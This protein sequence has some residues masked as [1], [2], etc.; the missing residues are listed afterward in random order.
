MTVSQ[1]V[2]YL[3]VALLALLVTQVSYATEIAPGRIINPG[4]LQLKMAVAYNS[5]NDEYFLT[6]AGT[7]DGLAQPAAL[8]ARLSP[9]GTLLG[10]EVV[11]SPASF[12]QDVSVAYNP[13]RNEYLVVWRNDGPADIF[14]RYLDGNGNP[15]GG[16]FGIAT[17]GDPEVD[18]EI[19]YST[20][21]KRYMVLWQ[22]NRSNIPTIVYRM[23]DGD[24]TS[25]TPLIGGEVTV[26]SGALSSEVAY[27]SVSN[28]FLVVFS[29]ETFFGQGVFGMF[30]AGDGSGVTSGLLTLDN[31]PNNQQTPRIAYAPSNDRWLVTFADW[32]QAGSNSA[33][34]N[35]VLVNSAGTVVKQFF[36]VAT[37]RAGNPVSGGWD[38]PGDVAFNETTGTFFATWRLEPSA[39]GREVNP[40]DGSLL[41]PV[42][43]SNEDA[44]PIA[45]TTRPDILDPQALVL[46]RSSVGE[47]GV[48]V[49]IVSLSGFPVPI[50]RI[51]DNSLPDAFFGVFYSH[52]LNVIGDDTPLTFSV[53]SGN[54][55]SIGLSLGATNGTISGT[56][57]QLGSFP[58]TFR[59]E[60]STVP[61]DTDTAD[62][63]LDIKLKPPTS[64]A[65][66]G[67]IT[68][69]TPTLSWIAPPAPTS[70][71]YTV[72]IEK[73]GVLFRTITTSST[74]TTVSPALADG[75]YSW[76][77]KATSSGSDSAFSDELSFQ[78]DTVAPSPASNFVA[79]PPTGVIQLPLTA[80]ASSGDVNTNYGKDKA[81]DGIFTTSWSTPGRTSMVEEFL[82]VDTG[83]V[84]TL[85]RVRLRSRDVYG[86]LF[87]EDFQVQVSTD[88]A[89]FN[90]VATRTGVSIAANT[91]LDPIDFSPVSARYVKIR[92]TKTRLYAP[93][94]EFYAQ[95]GELEV[96]QPGGITPNA[97]S[98]SWQTTGDDGTSGTASFYQLRWSNAPITTANFSS[99][100]AV[101]GTPGSPKPSG[102]TETVTFTGLA[103][104]TQYF[105]GLKIGDDANNLSS[106]VTTSA[107]TAG[108]APAQIDTL[109][110][111]NPT[112]N[113]VKLSWTAVGDNGLAGLVTTYD[114]R[115]FTS[116]ITEANFNSATQ[117]TS[118]LPTPALHPN[119]QNM[120]VTGLNH[121]TTYFFAVKGV[122][123][124]GNK[125][126][127]SNVVSA[128]T[129]D[130]TPP[131]PPQDLSG[132][133]GSV[134]PVVVPATAIA[135]SGD[136]NTN[137][138]KDKVVDG[139]FTTSWS[140]PGR[141]T[142]QNE[143]ITVDVGG[144]KQ[145]TRVRLRSRD[146]FGALFPED[147]QIQVSTDGTNFTTVFSV[148]GASVPA[149]TWAPPHDFPPVDARFVRVFVTRARLY[150]VSNQFYVQIAEI[151]VSE[152]QMVGG[153][154]T[155]HFTAP[156]DN[157]SGGG[158]ASFY[159]FRYS[160][161]PINDNAD[162]NS[163]TQATGEPT[164]GDPGML[165]SFVISGLAFET[166]Y[167]VAG[168]AGDD[169]P[170]LSALSDVITVDT[171][172]IPPGQVI[173][174]SADPLDG[175]TVEL[176]WTAVA[177]D[178]AAG[179]PAFEYELRFS[180]APIT[181]A[182][183]SS[184]T[185]VTGLASPRAPGL[186]EVVPVNGLEQETT[187]YFG[188]IVKDELGNASP[189]ATVSATTPDDTPPAPAQNF[190]ASA[191]GF[192]LT[193][194]PL[195]AV[196]SSGDVNT[197]FG[198]D[199]AVDGN[200]ITSWSTP[201]RTSMV[202]E[203]ISVDTGASRTLGRVRL[204]SRNVFGGLFPEDFEVQLSPNNLTFTTV[205]T[206][207]GVTIAANTWLAPIDF[208]PFAGARFVRI[209]ITKTRL[210][211][212]S[213][214]F[215]AQ[216]AE[217]EVSQAT[218]Q[219]DQVTL[220]WQAP[221]DDG[222]STGTATV[223]DVR[224]S[225]SS[226]NE[227]N[228]TVANPVS[229]VPA[230]TAPGTSQSVVVTGL[231]L[232]TTVHFGIKVGDEAGNFSNLVT[233]SAVTGVAD[234]TPPGPIAD[235]S[236]SLIDATRTVALTAIASSG[237]VNTNYGKDKAVDGVFTTS[238]STPGRT[239][240]VEE[241]LTVDTGAVRTLTRVRL[242]SRDVYGALFPEDFQ[243]QV[244]TDNATFN[245]VAT[246]TGVTIAANTWLD[247]IDFPP[248][249]ARYVK[250]RITKT[251]LYAPSNEFYAQ[252]GE[253][254]VTEQA[255]LD[256][257]IQAQWTA[258]G[259]DGTS[260][261][262]AGY[263]IRI[264][265]SLITGANFDAATPVA[266][267]IPQASPNTETFTFTG[268]TSATQYWV[269][270]K[271]I[272]ESGN[273]S[274]ISNVETI[275]LP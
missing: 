146:V 105:F 109:V 221:G 232:G 32:E 9:S 233:D 211:A 80:V 18:P 229:G 198:K 101:P 275:T 175:D 111:S 116:S 4:G 120:T 135:S 220:S 202:E 194:V 103:D 100:T 132:S 141:T 11:L 226:L 174:L 213:N 170:N 252:I 184:A 43:L 259:D 251:R 14:G 265:T 239:S 73:D 19:A 139:N 208:T 210:Y 50:P 160:T 249:S 216:V 209:R 27:G 187:Y 196:A 177:D 57:S 148:T 263:D 10:T 1:A 274:A 96:Y 69:N 159:D 188:L 110:A 99:A 31:G 256:D 42:F 68:D 205:A 45:A 246:R 138:G 76:R 112:G 156:G 207:T 12:V 21:S 134:N 128:T 65:P 124:R 90:T 37:P 115:Y 85:T 49:G 5:E 151:E 30:V 158:A 119:P 183:F 28:R 83:A 150:S 197:D 81:V 98:I 52:T 82:T 223:N 153:S 59:V 154:V 47:N 189:L 164:P 41:S 86:A 143:F 66:S 215:Y 242:R 266:G 185:E 129:S 155:I 93:S 121:T 258:S 88:N 145:L 6:Y 270:I 168:K 199:K 165:Q 38:V 238:W 91:W 245:T 248:V 74:S 22:E 20:V 231:P 136:V 254:E 23:I 243:V 46:W 137:Y 240:M 227:G 95:I 17:S 166:R 3:A 230:P 117:V 272:D 48:H 29:K 25:G 176:R 167:Y 171:P 206:R 92:I 71:S 236:L 78:V 241:F 126:P 34:V 201:G 253:L 260:G 191:G 114:V 218:S 97:L 200:F 89:T 24:S 61:P 264:S 102:Q 39:F 75:N 225:T 13:D 273:R 182:N 51:L 204:R 62:L 26:E 169:V 195:T 222:L 203:F 214:E 125:G 267:P 262:A 269:A 147:Y 172:G 58:F 162:F 178:G 127:I 44:W 212:P 87:P 123:D 261:V 56:A 234:T 186:E 104:E 228:F 173:D 64:V 15:I 35:A 180:T 235:L 271:V 54:L 133:S 67:N 152:A 219:L 122:D 77:V 72:E 140:T 36:I 250:T 193:P 79:Q 130:L 2:R 63:T 113:S 247:P 149:N 163:A 181:T 157:G 224:W 161:S 94:N 237:D 131:D 55:A 40:D 8:G 60:D 7:R 108:V 106:L 217:I 255:Q 179:G 107:F 53:T 33:D 244:S 142:M 192:A 268:L 118:G 257:Q 84:R 16:F 190:T 70:P 144:I